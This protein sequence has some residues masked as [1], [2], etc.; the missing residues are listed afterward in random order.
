MT[1]EKHNQQ[2]H[3]RTINLNG[4]Y[5]QDDHHSPKDH[6]SSNTIRKYSILVSDIRNDEK[7]YKVDLNLNCHNSD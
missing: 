4:S 3:E 6:C 2:K 7:R 5:S 1:N